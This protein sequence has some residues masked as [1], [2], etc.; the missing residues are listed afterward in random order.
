MLT[1]IRVRTFSCG[2]IDSYQP[3]WTGQLVL[4]HIMRG[5]DPS[6][7]RFLLVQFGDSLRSNLSSDIDLEA[8]N[9]NNR[10]FHSIP[11]SKKKKKSSNYHPSDAS[12]TTHIRVYTS[13]PPPHSHF[14]GPSTDMQAQHRQSQSKYHKGITNASQSQKI[15]TIITPC[16]RCPRPSPY[17]IF[18]CSLF[19]QVPLD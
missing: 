16:P 14:L 5:R 10:T 11:L 18:C 3:G 12:H 6:L 9:N 4:L 8:N 1:G 15:T 13:K 19:L 7:D 17:P 2:R